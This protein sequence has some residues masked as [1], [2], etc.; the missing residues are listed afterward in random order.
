LE[1][2]AT[3]FKERGFVGTTMRDLAEKV[4]I[5]A[6]SLYNHIEGKQ[7]LLHDICMETGKTFLTEMTRVEAMQARP[8]EQLR[9]MIAGHIRLLTMNVAAA[10]VANEEWRHLQEPSHTEFQQVRRD[11]EMR[12][13]RLIQ[14]AMAAGEIKDMHPQIVLYTVFSSLRWIQH[15]YRAGRT[16][17]PEEIE[18]TLL[19]ILM[20]GITKT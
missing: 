10:T 13:G 20:Q 16:V 2:A 4:G 14:R 19:T 15:W 11:Y 1:A 12:F 9:A 5:E 8:A 18:E 6:A 3:L 17:T 7:A